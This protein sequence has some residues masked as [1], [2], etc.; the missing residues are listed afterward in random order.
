MPKTIDLQRTLDP[1]KKKTLEELVKEV[2]YYKMKQGK[3][4]NGCD[5]QFRTFGQL[6]EHIK[7]NQGTGVRFLHKYGKD[8]ENNL[9]TDNYDCEQ[10]DLSFDAKFKLTRHV[11]SI[12]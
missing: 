1:P 8:K 4:C 6:S 12:D 2:E 7:L 9:E 11:R 3:C 5:A 10:C